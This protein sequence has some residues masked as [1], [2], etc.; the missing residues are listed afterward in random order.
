[1]R[2]SAAF[3]ELHSGVA[4]PLFV[5]A[6]GKIWHP[7]LAEVLTQRRNW[8]APKEKKEPN[9]W[10]I[11]VTQTVAEMKQSGWTTWTTVEGVLWHGS[12]LAAV[13]DKKGAESEQYVYDG[14]EHDGKQPSPSLGG[15]VRA[16]YL[17]QQN[18]PVAKAK[19]AA[20]RAKL[21]EKRS[22]GSTGSA[23][24]EEPV[25]DAPEAGKKGGRP[26]MTEEQKAAAKVK[27]DAKKAAE[28]AAE[29][30][31]EQ[32]MAAEEGFEDLAEAEAE[33]EV[34][35]EVEVEA[36]AEVEAEEA[37][38][39]AEAE[40]AKTPTVEAKT[41]VAKVA[42]ASPAPKSRYPPPPKKLAGS[43]MA[44][45]KAGVKKMDLSL[46]PWTFKGKKYLTNDRKDVVTEDLEWVGR[47]NGVSIDKSI[48]EPAD[49]AAAGVRDE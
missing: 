29:A 33:A 9:A 36:E 16:S 39:E 21:A 10:N 31:E 38:A 18:D 5:D 22:S 2:S 12:R 26:K 30:T 42:E 35:A 27:R 32:E 19:A 23:A 44:S 25:A 34:E 1:L 24:R 37:E 20:Y 15:M 49:L 4:A 11:L 41:P 28:V 40:E 8:S 46:T 45:I 3:L 6:A 47:F 17:K 14:G 7:L 43:S 48:K 13:K